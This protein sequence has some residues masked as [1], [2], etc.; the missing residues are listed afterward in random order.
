MY[1][2]ALVFYEKSLDIKKKHIPAD[3]SNIAKSYHNMG[4]IYDALGRYDLAMEHYTRALKIQEKSL[5]HEHPDIAKSYRSIGVI[6][7]KKGEWREAL[8]SY[9]KAAEI[10]RSSLSPQHPYVIEV[11]EDIRRLSSRQS[12]FS[13]VLDFLRGVLAI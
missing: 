8:A 12:L 4:C 3:H 7:E 13:S 2:D 5:P 1:V 11:N 9:E 6:H 10:Y